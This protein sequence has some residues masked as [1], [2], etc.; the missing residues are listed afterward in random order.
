[1]DER[2]SW[3]GRVA[4]SLIYIVLD[5]LVA[6]AAIVIVTVGLSLTAGLAITVVGGI[7]ALALMLVGCRALGALERWRVAQLL[8]IDIARPARRPLQGSWWSKLVGVI[9]DGAGWKAF[10]WCV[11]QP[12][13]GSVAYALVLAA[14]CGGIVFA[15]APLYVNQLPAD[16]VRLLVTDVHGGSEVAALTAVGIG[17]LTAAP[18]VTLGAAKLEG[19]IAQ[20]L[21]GRDRAAELEV[22]VS[23][24]S[25]RRTQAVDAAEAERRRI[26]RDLHDGAQQRLVS[27]GMSL[28]LAREKLASDPDAAK[29]LLEEA[30]Q[31]AKAAMTELRNLARGIHPAV[32]ADRGLDAALSG[33]AARCTVPVQVLVDVPQRPSAAIEGVAYYVVA[34]AL[35]N[36]AKHA[37]A[38]GATVSVSQLAGRLVVEVVDDGRGGARVAPGGGLAGLADRV[39]SVDGT[40]QLDSPSGGPT[41]L[42]VDLPVPVLPAGPAAPSPE[43]S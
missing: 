6:V 35:T 17:L 37:H 31:E 26:E 24:L 20:G 14:W 41:R 39:A 32:L 3:P 10:A 1:M 29:A 9:G 4:R 22:Q 5:P 43:V 30:H 16:T 28:G 15:L 8:G 40:L 25:E 42:R 7:G 18:W 33:L 23:D 13:V 2:W 11:V 12:I 19:R 27:L 34:E 36:V 21:L 38:N